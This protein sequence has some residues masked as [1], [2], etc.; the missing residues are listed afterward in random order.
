MSRVAALDIGTVRIGVALSDPLGIIAQPHAVLRN[1]PS[2]FERI[3]ELCSAQEVETLVIG[4]PLRMDGR[5]GAAVRRSRAFAAE[6][7]RLMPNMTFV[8]WDERL[9]SVG[10]ER[11][12]RD[13]G[14][15]AKQSR[16]LSDAIAASLLLEGWL[17]TR[18][19]ERGAR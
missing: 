3:R 8:E 9:S 12:L 18:N 5:A 14:K 6:L 4:L 1:D 11:V 17:G 19:E 7:R 16:G 10:A 13:V 15:S 2:V